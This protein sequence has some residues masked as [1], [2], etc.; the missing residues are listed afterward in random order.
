MSKNSLHRWFEEKQNRPANK[1]ETVLTSCVVSTMQYNRSRFYV[2]RLRKRL[3]LPLMYTTQIW[4]IYLIYKTV[5]R[6]SSWLKNRNWNKNYKIRNTILVIVWLKS[7]SQWLFIM[8]HA[9]RLDI[10]FNLVHIMFVGN[11]NSLIKSLL[12]QYLKSFKYTEINTNYSRLS[13]GSFLQVCFVRHCRIWGYV[14]W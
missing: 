1:N 2:R 9:E 11:G 6:M 8:L 5:K 3:H 10:P 13:I 14:H 4:N 12:K 7:G